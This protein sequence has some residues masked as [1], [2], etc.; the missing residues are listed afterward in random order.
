MGRE[1]QR[2]MCVDSNPH[3]EHW[4]GALNENK[5]FKTLVSSSVYLRLKDHRLPRWAPR[6][7]DSDHK[8]PVRATN[9]PYGNDNEKY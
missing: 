3:P 6:R 4:P 7:L 5:A 1:S 9:H 8:R 2:N